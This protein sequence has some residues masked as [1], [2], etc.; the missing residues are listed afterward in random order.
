MLSMVSGAQRSADDFDELSQV[1]FQKMKTMTEKSSTGHPVVIFENVRQY[2]KLVHEQVARDY[3]VVVLLN[4]PPKDQESRCGHCVK[5]EENFLITADSIVPYAPT[6]RPIF[7]AILYF[8]QEDDL[9]AHLFFE[10]YKVKNVPVVAFSPAQ[11][12]GKKQDLFRYQWVLDGRDNASPAIMVDYVNRVLKTDYRVRYTL[13]QIALAN[14]AMTG[15][16]G[17]A[18]LVVYLL[19]DL[20]VSPKVWFFGSWAIWFACS[21]GIIGKFTDGGDSAPGVI[22]ALLCCGFS[23]FLVLAYLATKHIKHEGW[24]HLVSVI[25][26]AMAFYCI[27]ALQNFVATNLRISVVGIWPDATYS[28]GT[29]RDSQGFM[30]LDKSS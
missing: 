5:A 27:H 16:L 8:D 6:E 4:L 7:F 23:T 3:D 25:C 22:F 29:L 2:V 1:K 15:A 18:F 13:H 19:Y 28:R 14:V 10:D 21:S 11:P 9:A 26:V 20:I 30:I 12:R 17:V 24:A